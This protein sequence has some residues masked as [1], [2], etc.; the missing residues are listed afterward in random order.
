[1]KLRI[2]AFVAALSLVAGCGTRVT[3][4]TT[5]AAAQSTGA[6]S[7]APSS[8]SSGGE[9]STGSNE[10]GSASSDSGTGSG[11]SQV[12]G[13][14]VSGG[15]SASAAAPASGSTSCSTSTGGPHS[16]KCSA[17]QPVIS[18]VDAP[19]VNTL[20]TPAASRTGMSSSGMIPP[21]KTTMSSA[22]RSCSAPRAA[23]A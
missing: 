11:G 18:E 5:V 10:A 16:E 20:A 8:E 23:C 15:G 7:A 12:A 17:T 1:M 2:V 6:Q 4:R 9:L 22:S 14:Q 13:E 3:D 21:P 19:G